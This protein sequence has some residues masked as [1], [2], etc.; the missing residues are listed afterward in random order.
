MLWTLKRLCVTDLF[1][2]SLSVN[3]SWYGYFLFL[4]TSL[5][6]FCSKMEAWLTVVSTFL[7]V[8]L[9]QDPSYWTPSRGRHPACRA[10]HIISQPLT[11]E[12]E[13]LL[14]VS[15]DLAVL[16]GSSGSGERLL[17]GGL[18]GG[19]HRERPSLHLWDFLPYPP[20]HQHQVLKASLPPRAHLFPLKNLVLPA[21]PIQRALARLHFYCTIFFERYSTLSVNAPGGSHS[22]ILIQ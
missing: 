3:A 13:R 4:R 12:T 16:L 11:V 6:W 7:T 14:W 15:V 1:N 20:V 2:Q 5:V 18:S 21:P 8:S 10:H 17:P 9:S 22:Q 19:L